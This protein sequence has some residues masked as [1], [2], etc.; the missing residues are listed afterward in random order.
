MSDHRSRHLFPLR[1]RPPALPRMKLSRGMSR[2][3]I[4]LRLLLGLMTLMAL[5][6]FARGLHG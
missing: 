1:E 6:N 2:T 4:F 5:Y 3:L